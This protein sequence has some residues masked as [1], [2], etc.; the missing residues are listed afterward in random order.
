LV[1]VQDF[2]ETLVLIRLTLKAVLE[3]VK[4]TSQILILGVCILL[5]V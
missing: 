3:H 2:K 1:S 4:I 5:H